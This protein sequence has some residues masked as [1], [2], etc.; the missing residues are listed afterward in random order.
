MVKYSSGRHSKLEFLSAVSRCSDITETS[1]EENSDAV[2]YNW[3]ESAAND[4]INSA[5][6]HS[7]AASAMPVDTASTSSDNVYV[8]C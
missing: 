8:I 3:H 7:S 4:S 2:T 1:S 6:S 5:N